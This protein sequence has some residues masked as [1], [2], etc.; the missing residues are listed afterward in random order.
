MHA[1]GL[2]PRGRRL[3]RRRKCRH[4]QRGGISPDRGDLLGTATYGDA[5]SQPAYLKLDRSGSNTHK[6][7]PLVRLE[8]ESPNAP[9]A[10]ARI[11]DPMMGAADA[12]VCIINGGWNVRLDD[13]SDRKGMPG[14]LDLSSPG[15]P[16]P[17]QAVGTVSA[18]GAK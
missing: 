15:P 12:V 8:K 2:F 3:A 9:L 11:T 5:T 6:G 7:I 13:P 16:A 18:A 10:T 14:V 1:P 17:G 4:R